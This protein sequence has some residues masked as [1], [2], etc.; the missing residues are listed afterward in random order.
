MLPWK[1][2]YGKASAS[3]SWSCRTGFGKGMLSL[4]PVLL[5][6]SGFPESH[7]HK[8]YNYKTGNGKAE[9]VLRLERGIESPYALVRLEDQLHE[10]KPDT[11]PPQISLQN[12]S[13]LSEKTHSASKLRENEKNFGGTI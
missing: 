8:P 12:T 6:T 3:I 4:A 2:F 9:K 5:S 13:I 1:I 11:L 10:Q 7:R